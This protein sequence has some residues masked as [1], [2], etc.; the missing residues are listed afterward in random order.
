M[1]RA[2]LAAALVAA[3]LALGPSSG[4]ASAPTV[5]LVTPAN[6]V[7]IVS[8]TATTTFPTFSWRVDWAE[9]EQ[10]LVTWQ[11]AADPGFTRDASSESQYCAATN[12]NCWTSFAPQRVWGPPYGSVWYWR[13]GVSTS[14]GTV[15]SATWSFNAVSP[16]DRDHDG[17][18]DASDN[19]PAVPNA[20]QRDSNH[21]GKGDA[22]QP[23]RVRPRVHV[24]PGSAVRGKRAYITARVA[25]DRG[26]V[27]MRVTLAHWGNVMYG[28]VFTWAQSRW[29]QPATFRTRAPLPR[30]LP[31]GPYQACVTASDKAGNRRRSCAR[32][33]VR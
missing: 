31:R 21:D 7:T 25:D 9:P 20:T 27:R 19:C 16:A 18:A 29:D 28:G 32:Y 30:F 1:P 4:A 13:V 26:F 15:Y 12:V 5:T 23:D 2:A 11:V 3:A 6:G 10:T 24:F 22:C 14:S 33:L 17:V 8:S